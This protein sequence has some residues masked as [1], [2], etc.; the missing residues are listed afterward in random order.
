MCRH[1][2]GGELRCCCEFGMGFKLLL[3]L[4]SVPSADFIVLWCHPR[5]AKPPVGCG[6]VLG[7]ALSVPASAGGDV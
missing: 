4:K 6:G 2:A 3:S 1:W 5:R 7:W